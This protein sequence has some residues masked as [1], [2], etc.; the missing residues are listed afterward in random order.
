MKIFLIILILSYTFTLVDIERKQKIVDMINNLKTTWKAKVYNRDYSNLI[1]TWKETPE[2][3][4]PEKTTFKTSNGALPESYDIR[5]I[6]P[7]CET[8]KEIRDQSKCGACWAFGATETMSDRICIHSK[9]QLQ[10][11]VSALHLSHFML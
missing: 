4:L 8:V 5:E 10:T 7:Q 9:G 6:Y 3:E 11:R 2:S 1:G